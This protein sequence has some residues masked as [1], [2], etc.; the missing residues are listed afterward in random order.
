VEKRRTYSRQSDLVSYP[1]FEPHAPGLTIRKSRT[2]APVSFATLLVTPTFLS[3]ARLH[4]FFS[5]LTSAFRIAVSTRVMETGRL[6]GGQGAPFI[7]TMN[8]RQGNGGR[9]S[10]ILRFLFL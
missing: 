6:S 4:R 2:T 7:Q 9:S 1:E 10:R 8:C 5:R 3:A